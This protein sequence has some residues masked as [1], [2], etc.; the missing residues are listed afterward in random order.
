MLHDV[1]ASLEVLLR[2]QVP[3][4]ERDVDVSFHAPD[5]T[6]AAGLS[7]PTVDLFLW[8]VSRSAEEAAAGRQVVRGGQGW[9]R[10]MP[11]ARVR[12][13]YL[14]TA[15]TAD[16]RDEHQL[17]AAVLVCLLRNRELPADAVVGALGATG[18]LPVLRVG[19]SDDENR[20]DLWRSLGGELKPAIELVVTASVDT[21]L[22]VPVPAPPRGVDVRRAQ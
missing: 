18:P 12:V 15:W 22:S 20:A 7:R 11:D 1:D 6:W 13:R 19:R 21:S 8:D 5:R 9:S 17:L 14:V 3:L 2:T 10:S 16:V 4:P